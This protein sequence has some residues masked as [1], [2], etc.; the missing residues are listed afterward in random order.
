[1]FSRASWADRFRVLILTRR[2]SA[3]LLR[4]SADFLASS[5]ACLLV[6]IGIRAKLPGLR[7]PHGEA[8]KP[9]RS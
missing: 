1:M 2:S 7:K 5:R 3:F 9:V 6:R 8:G 4:T